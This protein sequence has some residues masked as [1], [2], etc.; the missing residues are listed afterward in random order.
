MP[1]IRVLYSEI[2][3][4]KY[5]GRKVG[6]SDCGVRNYLGGSEGYINKVKIV[7]EKIFTEYEQKSGRVVSN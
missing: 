6:R 7:E 5:I 4:S 2:K 1:R 3:P